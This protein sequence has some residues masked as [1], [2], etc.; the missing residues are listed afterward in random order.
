M[1]SLVPGYEYDIFISYRQKD[2][3]G[4][5]QGAPPSGATQFREAGW[6]SE[7]VDALKTELESTFKEEISVYFDINP[8][9]GLLETH[10]VDASLKD[11]LKCLIF[12][13][14]I[15][16]TYCDPKSF[17][18]E[19]EFKVFLEKASQDQFGPKIKLSN[20]N[21]ASRVLPIL[22]HDLKAED[23]M[24]VEK[25]LGG[26][27][28]AIEFIYKESGVN[29]PLSPKD[30]EDKNTNKTNYRN[31]LNRVANAIDEII[32]ALNVESVSSEKE[33]APALEESLAELSKEDS[34]EIKKKP[35]KPARKTLMAQV[36]IAVIIVIAAI[37]GYPKIFKKDPLEKLRSSG[38][39]IS[40]AIMPFQNMT[41]DTTWN[42]WQDGIQNELITS[43]TNSEELKVRQIESIYSLIQNEGH[44]KYASITPSVASRISQKLDA[45]IFIYGSI[46]QS[47]TAIRLNAQLID[48]ETE[49]VLKAFQIETFA[50]EEN[51][52]KVVDSLSFII[53]N[54]LI[55][56]V[57]EKKLPG[58]DV[59]Q[60]YLST[61]SPEAF[62][63][64]LNGM[65]AFL[66]RDYPTSRNWFL[67]S[68][69]ID[70]SFLS[71]AIMIS[72][73]YEYQEMYEEGREWCLKIYNK[74][75]QMT[76]LQKI[77]VDYLYAVLFETPYEEIKFL[78][79]L[80]EL[81]PEYPQHYFHLG[82]SYNI[83]SLYDKAIPEFQ[84]ALEI[85]KKWDTKPVW[86]YNYTALGYAYHKTGEYK[87]EKKT[88]KIAEKDFP[89][90]PDLI[91]SKTLLAFAEG[92]TI[93]AEQYIEKLKSIL[94]ANS[95][96]E[97]QIAFRLGRLYEDAG[98]WDK[99]EKYI[100]QSVSLDSTLQ[101]F[102][103]DRPG[104]LAW[105]L[106][107]TGRNINE[108]MELIEKFMKVYPEN[109]Y[110]MA[111]KGWG[112]YKQGKNLESLELLEKA[113]ELRNDY[114]H[115]LYLCIDEVKK[116]IAN[117]K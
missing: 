115:S 6:V 14:I 69:T 89:D 97:A 103:P 18:W 58:S 9:D 39:R 33:K 98:V 53:R 42:V 109:S 88:Y 55:L 94:N 107:S 24:L 50:K 41:N 64:Y 67:Q 74:K 66:K 28:R 104:Y 85:Y 77:Q 91:T 82:I 26:F 110:Y 2:N 102:N 105:F 13:P 22:I 43:L 54:F 47:G 78:K 83:L 99:A 46:K 34:K 4:G 90:D 108:G 63:Y 72:F 19:H 32:S 68:L 87:E 23:K 62:R 29:R 3:K 60:P 76:M 12:I 48:P 116:A 35:V 7:F 5:R 20:G 100:R 70:S 11:K 40:V 44:V 79:Q 38:E 25:E 30:S 1:A 8:H 114:L 31:Q 112:L 57:L 113:R 73:S 56:T 51:I 27:I 111:T 37:I 80:I 10:D 17:A 15:S 96:S 71:P 75:D 61:N 93:E 84:K 45:N 36:L 86:I 16:R 101:P 21:V 81:E 59:I 95:I 106:I 52:F 65:K 92:D 117:Q 49:E